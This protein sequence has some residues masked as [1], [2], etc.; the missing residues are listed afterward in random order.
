M[1]FKQLQQNS[2]TEPDESKYNKRQFF[3]RSTQRHKSSTAGKNSDVRHL[4]SA[5]PVPC[6]RR[7][8]TNSEIV[9]NVEIMQENSICCLPQSQKLLP[10][11]FFAICTSCYWSFLF[12]SN[13]KAGLSYMLKS[14]RFRIASP[15]NLNQTLASSS[16]NKGKCIVCTDREPFWG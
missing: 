14:I 3:W 16:D 4:D 13:I 12:L 8:T 10:L 5:K 15:A 1:P 7:Q 9:N 11:P 2:I 6:E